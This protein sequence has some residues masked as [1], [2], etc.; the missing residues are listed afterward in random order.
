METTT[1]IT[2]SFLYQELPRMTFQP[3]VKPLLSQ[4]VGCTL[5]AGLPGA[6]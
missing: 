1:Q 3:V 4:Q 6:P 5:L 2:T